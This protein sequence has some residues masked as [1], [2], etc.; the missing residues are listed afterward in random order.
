M[1]KAKKGQQPASPPVEIVD[2]RPIP[3]AFKLELKR[4][5]KQFGDS[6]DEVKLASETEAYILTGEDASILLK[7]GAEK[8]L[9]KQMALPGVS[10]KVS[11]DKISNLQATRVKLYAACQAAPI[12]VLV[13]LG[14]VLEVVSRAAGHKVKPIDQEPLPLWLISLIGCSLN[15]SY[16]H[17]NEA[18]KGKW[19]F[20]QIQALYE[21]A[22]LKPA[23]LV[24]LLLSQKIESGIK[25]QGFYFYE[26]FYNAYP[27]GEAFLNQQT[28]LLQA[29]LAQAATD[30][31]LVA[32]RLLNAMKYDF[33]N[34]ADLIAE[35][36]VSPQKTVREAVEPICQACK[37]VVAP[38]IEKFVREGDT[39]QRFEAVRLLYLMQGDHALPILQE[40]F[41]VE[42]SDRVKLTIEKLLAAPSEEASLQEASFELP[43]LEVKTGVIPLGDG[44]KAAIK[45][46][47]DKAHDQAM[48]HF[49]QQSLQYQSPDRPK[50]LGK[51]VK[52]EP[53]AEKS[54]TALFK[55]IEGERT[56]VLS[57]REYS[58]AFTYGKTIVD[59]SFTPPN[60]EL[61]HVIRFSLA[62]NYLSA[63]REDFNVNWYQH[64]DLELYRSVCPKPFG[65]REVEAVLNTIDGF[66]PGMLLTSY[67]EM[68]TKYNEFFNWEPEAIWPAFA[69]NLT[70][71][72]NAITGG[73]K[74]PGYDYF[75]G[76]R[77]K[78][79]YRVLSMFPQ[80]PPGFVNLL[81]DIALSGSKGDRPLAQAALASIPKKGKK[82]AVALAD[83]R[84]AVRQ[85]AAEW[86]AELGEPDVVPDLKAAFAKEKQ[87]VVKGILI[88][89]LEKC[90]C[91]V[92]E[93]MDRKKLAKEA[94][95]GIKKKIPAS[96]SWF[97]FDSLPKIHWE[98][99][100]KPVEP[101]ILKWWIVQA[102]T[103]KTAI[104]GPLVRRYLQM[105]KPAD[106]TALSKFI[107]SS[108][109]A[110]DT[111]TANADDAREKAKKD[112]ASQWKSYGHHAY[113]KEQYKTEQG[114][115]DHLFREYS[116]KLI[117]SASGERGM[118]AVAA[119]NTP[120]ECVRAAENYIRKWFGQR[121][122]QC[123]AL[124]EFLSFVQH[125]MA[126]Q[127]LLGIANRFR[128][129]AIRDLAQKLVNDIAEREGW[130][131][132][133][134]ADR[135]IPDAGFVK[136]EGGGPATL[137]IDYGPRQFTVKL[138]DDL[139]A[140]ILGEGGKV[141]KS[142]PAPGKNDNEELAKEN[143]KIF[144]DAKKQAKDVVKR[145]RDRLYE[146]LCVQRG[147]PFHEWKSYLG[148]HPIM[149]RLCVRVVWAVFAPGEEGE[150]LGCFR[151][152]E[153][154]SLTNEA[155]DTV[156]FP[157]EAIVRVAHSAI[158]SPELNQAWAQHLKDYDVQ[159]LFDQFG[160][161]AYVL[162]EGK[163]K[164]KELTDF[165]GHCLRSFQL[166]GK[167]TKLGYVRGEAE[168][169]GMFYS[170][171]KPFP[172]LLIEAEIGFTGSPL[173]EEDIPSALQSLSFT[174]MSTNENA[175]RWNRPALELSKIPSVLLSEC[176]NDYKQIAAEGTGFDPDWEK[177]SGY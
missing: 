127:V 52:P 71:L 48:K 3:A 6:Q 19:P 86:L 148:D 146:A 76:E 145:Q 168:D 28:E 110:H 33:A 105:C 125:P 131:L 34:L 165:R 21:A 177:K 150:F 90:G 54:L 46:F 155:D 43:P 174:R 97:P 170:Y 122:A 23:D 5:L 126:L 82:V 24:K 26:D 57:E 134:L 60:A 120:T 108:W 63:D 142:L 171:R 94:D 113:W 72:R 114:L 161:D 102:V 164:D 53:L 118:L 13:R 2:D 133:Q 128:T 106:V 93:F 166:R 101:S 162:P 39:G 176:Y 100:G 158:V 153:D 129:K 67:L 169:G 65:L 156:T 15:D 78:N 42:K 111:K 10:H 50:W 85:A 159:T 29:F 30:E 119:I 103:Q 77:R 38:P 73:L 37:T 11:W 40:Q 32:I 8:E 12:P 91:D 4:V 75:Q 55:F 58:R 173:P 66:K 81:W 175:S 152:L 143:K 62:M 154:G 151:P 79:A 104:P 20:S 92:T 49:E 80:L 140:I 123:K 47:F 163:T 35:L 9:G 27:G 157:D 109:I 99:T 121:L 69:E 107:I 112:A 25:Q 130:T 160:R 116:G 149:G 74:R 17:R 68:N 45:A 135:T 88:S 147:W 124:V 89:A 139:E 51:P 136:P 56:V 7:L 44:P 70:L 83:G 59:D 132:D 41:A 14:E 138:D 18:A 84:Q 87:E 64:E 115:Q 137:L 31:K 22:G 16:S 172:S 36:A 141:I 167:A 117:G 61:I 1:A 96:L 98:D 144:S 95:E